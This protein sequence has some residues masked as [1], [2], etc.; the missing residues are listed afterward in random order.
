MQDLTRAFCAILLVIILF[1]GA[2]LAFI[3]TACRII[4]PAVCVLNQ[5]L[6]KDAVWVHAV[7]SQLRN[8][9]E[10]ATQLVCHE[11]L[12]AHELPFVEDAIYED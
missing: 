5:R 1:K 12:Y 9:E 6:L 4:L 7:S 8:S 10:H 2:R 3:E 11:L